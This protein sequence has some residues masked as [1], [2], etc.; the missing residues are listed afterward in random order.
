MDESNSNDS[1]QPSAEGQN[2]PGSTLRERLQFMRARSRA[3][4]K[5]L[6]ASN[7]ATPSSAG[8]IEPTQPSPAPQGPSTLSVRVD[9]EPRPHI[10]L[11]EHH[12]E[13]PAAFVA[14]QELHLSD[15]DILEDGAAEPDTEAVIIPYQPSHREGVHLGPLEYAFPV[16]MDA[17]VKDD[18]ETTMDSEKK[19]ILGFLSEPSPRESEGNDAMEIDNNATLSK[20]KQI[21]QRLNNITIHPDLN[22]TDPIPPEADSFR[23]S[24]WAEYSSA[25]FQFLGFFIDAATDENAHI[26]IYAREG[27]T[28]QIVRNYLLGKGFVYPESQPQATVEN[29]EL[30]LSRGL[31]SFAI[32]STDNREI[33]QPS[34]S[35]SLI[36]ALDNS[37]NANN[38]SIKALRTSYGESLIPVIRPIVSSSVEH[39]ELCLPNASNIKR[40]RYLLRRVHGYRDV[41]EL[42]DDA[43]GV[44]EAAEEIAS[45]LNTEFPERWSLPPLELVDFYDVEYDESSDAEGGISVPERETAPSRQK[46]WRDGEEHDEDNNPPKKQ[47]TTPLE[48]LAEISDSIKGQNSELENSL[49]AA[50]EKLSQL[51]IDHKTEL[52]TLRSAL[53]T[54]QHRYESRTEDLHKTRRERDLAQ[55]TNTKSEQRLQRQRDEITKL[56]E[57]RTA[58]TEELKGARETIKSGGGSAAELE[59]VKEEVRKLRSSNASLEKTTQYEKSQTEYTRQQ[60]QNAS[61]AAAQSGMEARQ[62]QEENEELKRKVASEAYRLKELKLKND[63]NAYLAQVEELKLALA[64]REKLLRKREEDLRDLMKNRPFRR[65]SSTTPR[66][67]SRPNSPGSMNGSGGNRGSALRSISEAAQ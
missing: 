51:Q 17:R 32:R 22:V 52:D 20:L 9:K 66:S 29:S 38:P 44:Q 40:F 15:K 7:S 14:P 34:H 8:D 5:P 6:R 11:H 12:E 1:A 45:Y 28:F 56:K 67:F 16:P 48:D 55:E 42:Q 21:I 65:A 33:R 54:L 43:L 10:M 59:T 25:K 60:Y 30:P 19:I 39:I 53:S 50:E 4:A 46:R 24:S 31:L 49:K 61:T 64:S 47:R 57:E 3:N 23:Q 37:F 41:G 18:Y 63:D 13:A 62:L 36:I 2:L 27:K 35:P 58:L 26:I